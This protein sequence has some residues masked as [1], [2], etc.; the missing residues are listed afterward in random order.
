MKRNKAI[1]LISAVLCLAALPLYSIAKNFSGEVKEKQAV[2]HNGNSTI[3]FIYDESLYSQKWDTLAQPLFWKQV[4]NLTEDSCIINVASTRKVLGRMAVKDWKS[5]S[6]EQKN[7][8]RDSIRTVHNLSSDA[9][10][11][12]T[13]GK[14]EFYN[15]KKVIPEITEAIRVFNREGVDPWYAQVILLI[16]SPGKLQKSSVGA[17]GPFQLMKSVAR[18]YGLKVNKYV[19][20]RADFDK[21]AAAA[22]KLLGRVCVFKVKQM[23]DAR[24]IEYNETD[25]WFRLMVLHAYHAGSGNVAA[26]INKINPYEGG[27]NLITTMWKT[28]A[29]G[30]K[31]ASQ[32]YSQIGLASLLSYN[33]IVNDKD[34]IFMA[35]GDRS[36]HNYKAEGFSCPDTLN[37]LSSC[38]KQYE[39]DLLNDIIPVEYFISQ[40]RMVEQE[41]VT[42]CTK[43]NCT[44]EMITTTAGKYKYNEDQLDELGKKLLKLRKSSEAI[45]ILKLNVKINPRSARAQA[46]LS[47]AYIRAG[48]K[49]LALQH[50]KKAAKLN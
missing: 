43:E 15:H 16:E 28:E 12:V 34:V 25:L 13:V 49:E 27:M 35:E 6:E 17:Y 31:N 26:V 42:V 11:F 18:K 3:R 41:L 22:A 33:E 14:K 10:V 50:S 39:T 2:S 32:N 48:N 9:S 8:F 36:F 19:D 46:S 40:I 44:Q 45:E 5:Q 20:E 7:C 23:L 21:S 47:E 24:C 30:F 37:Y 38:M 29:G 4:I 1:I